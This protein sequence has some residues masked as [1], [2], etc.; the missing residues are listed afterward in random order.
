MQV[1]GAGRPS[2]SPTA[3][4]RGGVR[5]QHRVA[6]GDAGGARPGRRRGRARERGQGSHDDRADAPTTRLPLMRAHADRDDAVRAGRDAVACSAARGAGRGDRRG[7]ARCAGRRSPPDRTRA[8][9]RQRRIGRRG[10]AL[11]RRAVGRFARERRALPAM[12]LTTDSERADRGRQ[13]LRLRAGVRPPGRGAR[14]ARRR[15]GRHLDERA[16]RRTSSTGCARRAPAA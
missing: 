9:V 3:G 7:R 10:A 6:P 16:A 2:A 1:E 13:R 15:G 11:R 4:D 8:G 5:A 12:A 14:P